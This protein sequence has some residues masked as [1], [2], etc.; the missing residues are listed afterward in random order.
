MNSP[1]KAGDRRLRVQHCG[2][3]ALAQRDDE[4][5]LNQGNLAIQIRKTRFDFERRRGTV[6]GRPALEHV[7]DI[8]RFGAVHSKG[9][10]HAVEKAP[11]RGAERVLGGLCFIALN[12]SS[13]TEIERYAYGHIVLGEF[14]RP[15]QPRT[16]KVAA[17]FT[18]AAVTCTVVDDLALERW[19]KL[20]WNIPLNGLSILGGGIDTA[21]IIGDKDLRQA[22]LGLMDEVI[23]AA[24]KCGHPL[25]SDAWREHVKRTETMGA[26]KP[27]T[28][29]D[30][31]AGRPLEIEPIWGEPLRRAVAAG[32]Q[33][34]R[35]EMI[36]AV[37][38]K[39]DHNRAGAKNL[40]GLT[41]QVQTS[42]CEK[43]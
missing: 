35:T 29:Q 19:R 20:I 7:G 8:D 40:N 16:R 32:G 42:Q 43:R 36:Y 27:S 14:D 12:R 11:G 1:A 37:L 10:K 4:L 38:K 13:R 18:R 21:A 3:R 28:L 30:W 31:E 17:E 15:S 5:R 6:S 26:Y 22:M 9:R 24:Q 39:L 33:M 41:G 34:P 25:P 23:A 2:C